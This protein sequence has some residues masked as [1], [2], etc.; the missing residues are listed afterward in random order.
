MN[1]IVKLLLFS[2]VKASDPVPTDEQLVK[3]S[4]DSQLSCNMLK[5][6]DFDTCNGLESKE[7]IEFLKKFEAQ[8][9]TLTDAHK[10]HLKTVVSIDTFV[11]DNKDCQGNEQSATPATPVTGGSGD[12]ASEAERKAAEA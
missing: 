4:A 8:L 3:T 10:G 2:S 5:G 1:N 12:Q 11:V 9:Q 6:K 7:Q